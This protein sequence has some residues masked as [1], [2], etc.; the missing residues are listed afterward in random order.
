[1]LETDSYFDFL[2]VLK[3]AEKERA[4]GVRQSEECQGGGEE[5]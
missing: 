2:L 4:D 1:L 3:K 5:G